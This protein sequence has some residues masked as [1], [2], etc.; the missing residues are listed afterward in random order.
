MRNR[1][2]YYSDLEQLNNTF[3]VSDLFRKESISLLNK[4]F[5]KSMK[6]QVNSELDDCLV[7]L[8]VYFANKT[9]PKP[10]TLSEIAK[11]TSV[12]QMCLHHQL[13]IVSRILDLKFV[14]SDYSQFIYRFGC[15]LH[16]SSLT[17]TQAVEIV[18]KYKVFDPNCTLRPLSLCASALYISGKINGERR[19][20]REV[21]DVVGVAEVSLRNTMRRIYDSIDL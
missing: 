2:D 12:E 18:D 6:V 4:F 7:G 17:I 1:D 3:K 11:A 14:Q 8:I 5:D 19:L 21:A 16:F 10:L 9:S 20:Q 13:K 15:E